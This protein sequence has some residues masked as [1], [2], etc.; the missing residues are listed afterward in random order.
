M[1]RK[2]AAALSVTMMGV[3][4]R[5]KPP[6]MLSDEEKALWNAVTATKPPEWFRADSA[7][8]LAEYCRAKVMCDVLDLQVKEAM[9]TG[10][11]K[12]IKDFLDMRDKES[13]R[14]TVLGTKMRLT[15]QARYV[16]DK[17]AVHDRKAAEHK[18]W[19]AAAG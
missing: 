13:R 6:E 12:V 4:P 18:P 2:S 17:A 14:L 15:Q 9:K 8:L 19:Q 16:P 7:P 5:L 1:A 10:E 11:P 3:Q